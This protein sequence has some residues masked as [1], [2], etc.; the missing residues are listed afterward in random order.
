MPQSSAPRDA[1]GA[2]AAVAQVVIARTRERLCEACA[3]ASALPAPTAVS[4]HVEG[5]DL[6]V[7]TPDALDLS[8]VG[9][10]QTA[11][12]TDDG[13]VIGGA[14]DRRTRPSA[15]APAHARAHR[16]GL[17]PAIASAGDR[18]V[19]A[20]DAVAALQ[21]IQRTG[22]P[23]RDEPDADPKAIAED[24]PAATHVHSPESASP[25]P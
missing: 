15:A 17:G 11:L 13:R 3:S 14:W 20:A 7:I 9:P 2:R 8:Q 24:A 12:L 22:A 10:A 4:V 18:L 21:A 19:H 5:T 23:P 1:S 6:F 25:T 16:A